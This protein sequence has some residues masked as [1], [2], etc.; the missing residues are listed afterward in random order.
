MM[1]GALSSCST[2]HVPF[3][4]VHYSQ[5]P[6]LP[7]KDALGNDLNIINKCYQHLASKNLNELAYLEAYKYYFSRKGSRIFLNRYIYY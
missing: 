7:E 3:R 5:L 2:F 1:Q 6:H 4:W